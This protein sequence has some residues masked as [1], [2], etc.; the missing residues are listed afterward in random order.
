[1]QV[2]NA[3]SI[4]TGLE[5]A[6][7]WKMHVILSVY[8]PVHWGAGVSSAGRRPSVSSSAESGDPGVLVPTQAAWCVA[9]SQER[10]LAWKTGPSCRGRT[11]TKA[12]ILSMDTGERSQHE[13][14]QWSHTPP[15]CYG[16]NDDIT[17]A[18][19]GTA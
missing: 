6:I 3:R 8:V 17:H 1:M 2:L 14:A 5:T 9:V 12:A 11:R 19:D 13:K 15:W 16:R 18:G 10:V 7:L 4:I